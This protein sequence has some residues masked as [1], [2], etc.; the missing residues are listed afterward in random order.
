[1]S[2][3]CSLLLALALA[4]VPG[5]QGAC[6]QPSDIKNINGTRTCAKV[7]DKSD[8]YYDLCCGGAELSLEPGTDMPYL[9]SGW[10][11]T[12]SS[13]VVGPRCELTVWSSRGKAGKSRKFSSGTYPRLEE[14]RRGLFGD[15][16]N[17]ISSLYCRCF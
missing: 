4:A 5:V 14:Y 7:Y 12:I 15:W 6:P 8:P 13:L 2:L 3:L 10:K 1:M 9:P 11:N 17:S 16:S